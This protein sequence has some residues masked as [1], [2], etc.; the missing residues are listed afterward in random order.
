MSERALRISGVAGVSH[1]QF[2][3]FD[4]RTGIEDVRRPS[5]REG[6]GLAAAEPGLLALCTG[7]HTG[8]IALA[9]ELWDGAPPHEPGWEDVVEVPLRVS[10]GE[11]RVGL[12]LEEPPPELRAPLPIGGPRCRARVHA[13]GRDVA[14]DGVAFEPVEEHLVQL[15]ETEVEDPIRVLRA[16]SGC[17]TR[18]LVR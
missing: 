6:A 14:Y 13:T 17:A 18:R 4:A 1:H 12:L 5:W 9:V 7:I 3:L 16:T 11:L 10:P 15:W 8:S 2:F